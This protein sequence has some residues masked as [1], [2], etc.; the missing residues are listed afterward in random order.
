MH[1]SQ[2][3]RDR[4]NRYLYQLAQL[5]QLAE[6]TQIEP[7]LLAAYL[8]RM[9]VTNYAKGVLSASPFKTGDPIR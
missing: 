1:Q 3:A 2:T 7:A 9:K 5:R 4:R 6:I 8:H